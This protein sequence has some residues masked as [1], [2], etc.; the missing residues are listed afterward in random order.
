MEGIGITENT[1]LIEIPMYRFKFALLDTKKKVR[2]IIDGNPGIDKF[3][4]EWDQVGGFCAQVVK[5]GQTF[6]FMGIYDKDLDVLVHEASHMTDM[7]FDF[8][9]IPGGY[10]NT[11]VR[12]YLTQHI[13]NEVRN[14]VKGKLR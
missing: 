9:T 1:E 4:P 8:C 5:G 6:Y 12:A 7:I 2:K 3:I 10:D 14:T 13:F 11:E